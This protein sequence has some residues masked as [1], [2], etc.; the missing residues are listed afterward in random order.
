MEP[1]A[2]CTK[3]FIISLK[4]VG[5]VSHAAFLVSCSL[6]VLS[7]I[8]SALPTSNPSR[9]WNSLTYPKFDNRL[10]MVQKRRKK[11]RKKKLH[12]EVMKQIHD[13]SLSGFII[14]HG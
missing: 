4:E 9:L 11:K 6:D 8:L 12:G 13:D 3:S 7:K 14:I 10:A 5:F 2:R 1:P